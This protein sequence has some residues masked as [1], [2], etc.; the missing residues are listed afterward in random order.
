MDGAGILEGEKAPSN[1]SDSSFPMKG[2][3]DE[4]L[5]DE[6]ASVKGETLGETNEEDEEQ[7]LGQ[8][9]EDKRPEI[10]PSLELQE[11]QLE[12]ANDGIFKSIGGEDE[13][14][15]G[16]EIG[17]DDDNQNRNNKVKGIPEDDISLST[18]VP[19]SPRL[20][21]KFIRQVAMGQSELSATI[22]KKYK[23]MSKDN[24]EAMKKEN[25]K[26]LEAVKEQREI[27][28]ALELY[29][30]EITTHTKMA[31]ELQVNLN[32][33][34]SRR[35]DLDEKIHQSKISI[36]DSDTY[37]ADVTALRHMEEE[38]KWILQE[39]KLIEKQIVEEKEVVSNIVK[40][41]SGW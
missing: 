19:P 18:P 20:D 40:K 1:V 41:K 32:G 17:V 25:A 9:Q 13:E 10:I 30:G 15:T 27:E 16:T 39:E 34:R 23:K 24:D 2:S 6:S 5:I 37:H 14:S 28:T 22:R 29:D 12:D 38:V 11:P 33:I 26:L 31:E 3:L 35:E 4:N 36:S 8:V 21:H 7:K